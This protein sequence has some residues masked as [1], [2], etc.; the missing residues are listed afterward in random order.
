MRLKICSLLTILTLTLAFRWSSGAAAEQ[1]EPRLPEPL[2]MTGVTI[3]VTTTVDDMTVNGNC[4]LREA[5][6]A[7]QTNLPVDACPSATRDQHRRLARRALPH[8]P[9]RRQ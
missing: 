2:L 7:A 9:A 8:K 1:V 5:L 3:T 6:R 4:T